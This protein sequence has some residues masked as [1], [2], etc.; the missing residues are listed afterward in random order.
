MKRTLFVLVVCLVP[1]GLIA[2]V[3]KK[4]DIPLV[5]SHV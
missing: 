5:F 2:C 1:V 4:S 3:N